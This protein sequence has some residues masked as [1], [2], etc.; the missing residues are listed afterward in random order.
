MP[1]NHVKK[2]DTVLVLTGKD[3]GKKG[4]IM[5]VDTA[6]QRVEVEGLNMVKRHQKPKPPASPQGGI[7]EKSAGIHVSNVMLVEPKKGLP[8][9]VRFKREGGKK[10]RISVRTG[11]KI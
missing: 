2:G 7:V 1:K 6:H 11:E 4:K 9:R 5:L 10:V 3:A 8:T